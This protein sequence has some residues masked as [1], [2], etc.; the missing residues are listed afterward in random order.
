MCAS[1]SHFFVNKNSKLIRHWV[2]SF[3]SFNKW[4]RLT[5][6]TGDGDEQQQIHKK[7]E[8]FATKVITF[9]HRICLLLFIE[10]SR[11]F[12]FK[13]QREIMCFL[14]Y[15]IADF[16]ARLTSSVWH[17]LNSVA[18][19]SSVF[20]LLFFWFENHRFLFW[21]F[22]LFIRP[23]EKIFEFDSEETFI[24]MF[25]RILR[26]PFFFSSRVDFIRLTVLIP[27]RLKDLFNQFR[28]RFQFFFLFLDEFKF[29]W[30]YQRQE[31]KRKE[32]EKWRNVSVEMLLK[33]SL[34]ERDHFSAI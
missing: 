27:L 3:A 6:L 16:S 34:A 10:Q 28:F 7:T 19:I 5:S 21:A 22:S 15:N 33:N 32:E 1:K 24:Q 12:V 26:K 18:E 23:S 11:L 29:Q 4:L 2:V 30:K 17:H 31:S 9:A 20:S 25:Q 8:T 13:I 14:R